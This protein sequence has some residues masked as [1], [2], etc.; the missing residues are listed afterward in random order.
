[1]SSAVLSQNTGTTLQILD[2]SFTR[3]QAAAVGVLPDTT[4]NTIITALDATLLYN[5]IQGTSTIDLGNSVDISGTPYSAVQLNLSTT[6][7]SYNFGKNV[8]INNSTVDTPNMAIATQIIDTSG[9]IDVSFS[10]LIGTNRWSSAPN[11]IYGY[12]TED[13]SSNPYIIEDVSFVFHDNT[14]ATLNTDGSTWYA[15]FNQSNLNNYYLSKAINSELNSLDAGLPNYPITVTEPGF[16]TSYSLG[17]NN[18]SK[19]SS[20]F[21][22][23]FTDAATKGSNGYVDVP[24]V[25]PDVSNNLDPS[26]VNMYS[27]RGLQNN[28]GGSVLYP[29]D[30]YGT[31][32]LTQLDAS[33]GIIVTSVYDDTNPISTT[34]LPFMLDNSGT[35][36]AL[37]SD[38]SFTLFNTLFPGVDSST[39]F[40][41]NIT[42]TS[43]YGGYYYRGAYSDN[44]TSGISIINDSNSSEIVR[45][46]STNLTDNTAYTSLY[47]NR[48]HKLNI[49]NGYLVLDLSTNATTITQGIIT[50]SSDAEYLDQ[51]SSLLNGHLN[52]LVQGVTDRVAVTDFSNTLLENIFVAYDASDSAYGLSTYRTTVGQITSEMKTESQ[53]NIN[54]ECLLNGYRTTDVSG[55]YRYKDPATNYY[56]D[57]SSHSI[58][59]SDHPLGEPQG[60]AF[61]TDGSFNPS[62]AAYFIQV[63]G[64]NTL[65]AS[66]SPLWSLIY[67]ASGHPR[68]NGSIAKI[69]DVSGA[70][71]YFKPNVQ[72]S[73]LPLTDLSYNQYRTYLQPKTLVNLLDPSYGGITID[74]SWSIIYGSTSQVTTGPS[75]GASQFLQRDESDTSYN[76]VYTRYGNLGAVGTRP[77]GLNPKTYN[78]INLLNLFEADGSGNFVLDISYGTAGDITGTDVVT[79]TVHGGNIDLTGTDVSGTIGDSF[80]LHSVETQAIDA[81]GFFIS[82]IQLPL[83][84]YTNLYIQ[85]PTVVKL[86]TSGNYPSEIISGSTSARLK[87]K[88]EA[89]MSLLGS[90]QGATDPS[91][92]WQDSSNNTNLW[93]TISNPTKSSTSTG[94][95]SVAAYID[96]PTS[97]D[98]TNIAPNLE[99]CYIYNAANPSVYGVADI[100][101]TLIHSLNSNSTFQ[102][103]SPAYVTEL[104]NVNPTS[105]IVKVSRFTLSQLYE[106]VFSSSF[107]PTITYTRTLPFHQFFDSSQ[108]Y[109]VTPT[110]TDPSAS[111]FTITIPDPSNNMTFHVT[112]P[113]TLT[114]DF[115]IWY[116]PKDVHRVTYGLDNSYNR[117]AFI[118]NDNSYNV[119]NIANGSDLN[120]IALTNTSTELPG[121]YIQFRLLGQTVWVELVNGTSIGV[122]GEELSNPPGLIFG[123]NPTRQ[124]TLP[125]YRGY[126]LYHPTDPSYV[127]QT[128]YYTIHRYVTTGRFDVSGASI[129]NSPTWTD[130]Y[131]GFISDVSFTGVGTVGSIGLTTQFN[132]SMLRD[133]SGLRPYTIDLSGDPVTINVTGSSTDTSKHLTNYIL[134]TFPNPQYHAVSGR[135]TA[136]GMGNNPVTSE[137][138]NIS[139]AGQQVQI[140]YSSEYSGVPSV[141]SFGSTTYPTNFDLSGGILL[142]PNITL[143]G[144]HGLRRASNE[145]GTNTPTTYLVIPPAFL[146]YTGL[147]VNAIDHLPYDISTIDGAQ[148]VVSYMPVLFNSETAFNPFAGIT[149]VSINDMTFNRFSAVDMIYYVANPSGPYNIAVKGNRVTVTEY[150][151]GFSRTIINDRFIQDLTSSTDQLTFFNIDTTNALYSFAYGQDL[152][153]QGTGISNTYFIYFSIQDAFMHDASSLHIAT[154]E[155]TQISVY[156]CIPYVT[157]VSNNYALKLYKYVDNQSINISGPL[158]NNSLVIRP[159][160]RYT[161]D[162]SF[163]Q[164]DISTNPYTINDL[165]IQVTEASLTGQAWTIDSSFNV[166]SPFNL[167]FV[168]LSTGGIQSIKTIFSVSSTEPALRVNYITMPDSLNIKSA[169]GSP[170]MRITYNGSIVTPLVST[171]QINLFNSGFTHNSSNINQEV[172]DFNVPTLP[173]DI[174]TA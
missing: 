164:I 76:Y 144:P 148:L 113:S 107:S 28:T 34:V 155:S 146:E 159:F 140:D 41:F 124:I 73:D 51:A 57:P 69:S 46:D 94:P 168:S 84:H 11:P 6:D 91:A 61:T 52:M 147:A 83:G 162:V 98:N 66:G 142:N 108:T 40:S 138:Y 127:D 145:S 114:T 50:I 121:D 104:T 141:Q 82:V 63:N 43:E 12:V 4:Q 54:S 81:S 163:M 131:N 137:T 18:T 55:G 150:T 85:T 153:S 158:L 45:L 170:V 79:F 92:N 111:P 1:M 174:G 160:E 42:A 44:S 86:H 2:M 75:A 173:I 38:I 103:S 14:D 7:P 136:G 132:Q 39:D 118:Q 58:L 60:V 120:G 33:G 21:H 128:Q 102:L 72:I 31:W 100:H 13:P 5:I 95:V 139:K 9:A 16:N 90:I 47:L 154:G 106:D 133:A 87:F 19:S 36:S 165:L 80:T 62:V 10:L 56:W 70:N 135:I 32:R 35:T 96:D 48:D 109:S 53:F 27:I 78:G 22:T 161:H 49:V 151:T 26:N 130:I 125:W 101:L 99:E 24:T 152:R 167:D 110:F 3:V 17:S 126:P 169:D 23:F 119:L 89:V 8:L 115:N 30:E 20:Q 71:P 172:V 37:P 116:S 156:G 105:Y 64:V 143:Y 117:L 129:T 93:T 74:S 166:T 88:R 157:D 65:D 171:T 25:V 149:D 112:M 122:S 29:G 123:S 68:L 15:A 134:Y 59:Y 77:N 67:D 97:W